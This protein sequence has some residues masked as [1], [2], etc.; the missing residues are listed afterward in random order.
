MESFNDRFRIRTQNNAIRI[1]EATEPM[2]KMPQFWDIVR[3]ICRS[4]ASVAA[5]FSAACRSRSSREYYSKMCIVVEECDETLLW[6]CHFKETGQIEPA[7]LDP[8]IRETTELLKVFAK[9]R[10]TL[11]SHIT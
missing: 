6:L 1:A 2:S 8:I 4:S 9:T 11:K 10:K 3:Q 5:N 7:I